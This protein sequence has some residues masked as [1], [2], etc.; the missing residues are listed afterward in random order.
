MSEQDLG[1]QT[2]EILEKIAVEIIDIKDFISEEVFKSKYMD[3]DAV[4]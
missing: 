3:M 1:K 4:L 2:Q